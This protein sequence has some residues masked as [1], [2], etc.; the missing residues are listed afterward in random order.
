MPQSI[1][2]TAEGTSKN[3]LSGPGFYLHCD[4]QG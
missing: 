3:N 4:I 1:D 2:T